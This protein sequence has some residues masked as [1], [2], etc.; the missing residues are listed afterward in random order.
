MPNYFS[1]VLNQ[2]LNRTLNIHVI[3]LRSFLIYFV[4]HGMKF[5]QMNVV[6]ICLLVLEQNVGPKYNNIRLI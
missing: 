6:E 5:V 3:N 2:Q 1:L 4:V